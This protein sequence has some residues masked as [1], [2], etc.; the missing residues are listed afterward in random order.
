MAI[1]ASSTAAKAQ[2]PTTPGAIPNPG[3]YQGSTELQRQ[4]D[5]RDQ[6]LREEQQRQQQAYP[7]QRTFRGDEG[8]A[9][10]GGGGPARVPPRVAPDFA[11]NDR[12]LAAVRRKDYAAAIRI[13]RPLA[14]RG[15]MVAGYLMG[16]LYDRGMGVPEN[17]PM[18]LQYFR[19]S[20]G[21]GYSQSMRNL[22]TMYRSGEAGPVN[23]VEAY[24][25]YAL[26]LSHLVPGET[27]ADGIQELKQDL[28]EV[29][30]K[31][32]GPQIATAKK[33]ARETN[34]PFLR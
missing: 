10:Q 18:A 32:T 7:Q 26:S 5:Q 27:D 23:Y 16:A 33:L 17:H 11:A 15:D 34:I 25:W 24:R 8:A 4:S 22:G 20:A 1:A 29:S 6:Q 12:A 14:D 19:R 13:A 30:A 21:E 31:M 2:N 3:T 28:S 9:R